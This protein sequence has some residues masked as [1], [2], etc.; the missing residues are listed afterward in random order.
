MSGGTFEANENN[1]FK[2]SA[3]ANPL[4]INGVGNVGTG[5]NS[6]TT[7]GA[8]YGT[9][10]GG[11]SSSDT[12]TLSGGVTLTGNASV[13]A[14][15]DM[16]IFTTNPVNLGS[17]TL[18]IVAV[19]TLRGVTFTSPITGTGGL[20]LDSNSGGLV[21][22]AGNNSYSGP[23]TVVSGNVQIGG[24]V[25]V[26]STG[27]LGVAGSGPTGSFGNGAGAVSFTGTSSNS[28]TFNLTSNLTVNNPIS[29]SGAVGI[30]QIG[31]GTTVLNNLNAYSGATTVSAGTLE[32]NSYFGALASGSV[33]ISSGATFAL[34]PN[35]FGN[36]N[37]SGSTTP[38]NQYVLPAIKTTSAG[39]LALTVDTSEAIN[40]SSSG[41]FPWNFASLS[42]GAIGTVNYSGTFTPG[43]SGY[44]FG[45]G[46]GT[47]NFNTAISGSGTLTQTGAGTTI[48][49]GPNSFTGNI[50]VN[51][52]NLELNS[53]TSTIPAGSITV[54]AGGAIAAGPAFISGSPSGTLTGSFLPLINNSSAGAIALTAS[55]SENLDFSNDVGGSNFTAASLGAI[56]SATYSG[57]L[58]P[59]GQTYRLG[60]GGGTLTV[61][62]CAAR[63]GCRADGPGGFVLGHRHAEQH[64]QRL[65]GRHDDQ[66]RRRV[67]DQFRHCERRIRQHRRA[68]PGAHHVGDEHHAQRRHAA[69]HR[70]LH[71]Q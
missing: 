44:L 11:G 49:S 61:S 14:A 41:T 50:T 9:N 57:T 31:G 38:L 39:T 68:W 17:N 34:G 29:F 19:S 40:F 67:V 42:L 20:T 53:Y 55:T 59:I 21:T 10:T 33:T 63:R 65:F 23:T 16:L 46:G 66:R 7:L 45:G 28:L 69:S 25:G 8:I 35:Y 64:G 47:L 5:A 12:D 56:G 18:T 58:T 36:S 43:S 52:G 27:Y 2:N 54:N 32:I 37:V 13:E 26:L 24:T 71:S 60:G 51:A 4:V 6:L 22:L 15:N 3:Y 48:L 1:S 30:A 62:S 70:Q